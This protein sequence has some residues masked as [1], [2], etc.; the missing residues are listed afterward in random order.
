[1]ERLRAA[2]VAGVDVAHPAGAKISKLVFS[3]RRSHGH[4]H[5]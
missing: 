2:G 4:R 3:E 1:M 5:L